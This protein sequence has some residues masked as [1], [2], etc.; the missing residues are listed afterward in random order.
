MPPSQGR[1]RPCRRAR[2][3]GC[4]GR[5]ATPETRQPARHSC[6][7]PLACR[8]SPHQALFLAMLPQP[9]VSHQ[10]QRRPRACQTCRR[11]ASPAA[12]ACTHWPSMCPCSPDLPAVQSHLASMQVPA[13]R[14]FVELSAAPLQVLRDCLGRQSQPR[15]EQLPRSNRRPAHPP[16]AGAPNGQPRQRPVASRP[17]AGSQ[18]ALRWLLRCASAARSPPLARRHPG[19]PGRRQVLPP[20]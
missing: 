10:A 17:P 1:G 5:S 11:A 16:A 12:P 8:R 20:R 18:T 14:P 6:G 15:C 3:S 19:P 4:R 13:R 9:E 2:R 7:G